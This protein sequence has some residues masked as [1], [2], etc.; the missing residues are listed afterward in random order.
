MTTSVDI[1]EVR[2]LTKSEIGTSECSV[3]GENTIS[4]PLEN[5]GD[6]LLYRPRKI[7]VRD[8]GKTLTKSGEKNL[9]LI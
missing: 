1:F 8:V 5:P 4:D 7:F 2:I 6:R 9:P 3:T